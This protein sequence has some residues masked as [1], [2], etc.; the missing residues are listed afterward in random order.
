MHPCVQIVYVESAL[1]PFVIEIEGIYGPT[2]KRV[3]AALHL[4]WPMYVAHCHEVPPGGVQSLRHQNRLKLREK[5]RLATLGVAPGDRV[6]CHQDRFHGRIALGFQT[7]HDFA[8]FFRE[9]RLSSSLE[10]PG[11]FAR[12]TP[13]SNPGTQAIFT[14]HTWVTHGRVM[15]CTALLCEK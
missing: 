7:E 10:R 14:P 13:R 1:L 15:I 8:D 12:K 3:V 5:L 11:N 6:M 2:V 4:L 9:Y